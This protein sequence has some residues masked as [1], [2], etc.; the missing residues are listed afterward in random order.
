MIDWYL[1]QVVAWLP[2]NKKDDDTT[3]FLVRFGL[4]VFSS[5]GGA[6]S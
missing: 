6:W 1:P 3:T 2:N 4:T 5:M